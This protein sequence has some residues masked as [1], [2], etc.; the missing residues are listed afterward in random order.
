M[1]YLQIASIVALGLS[2]FLGGMFAGL[3]VNGDRREIGTLTAA[4]ACL[5]AAAAIVFYGISVNV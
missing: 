4:M 5:F 3:L 2:V 1:S